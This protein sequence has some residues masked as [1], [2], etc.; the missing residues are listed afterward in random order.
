MGST[1]MG[2]VVLQKSL[3]L[4][5]TLDVVHHVNM[6]HGQLMIWEFVVLS[7][8]HL[9]IFFTTIV[10][11]MACYLSHCLEI[12]LKCFSKTLPHPALRSQLTLLTKRLLDQMENHFPLRLMHLESIVLSMVLIR[13][14]SLSKRM[15]KFHH[16][17]KIAQRTS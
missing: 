15:K 10:L 14:A 11:T 6:L 9:L 8:H 3:L 2:T 1:K 12:K 5:T 13:S 17:R 16:L 7:V 4:E